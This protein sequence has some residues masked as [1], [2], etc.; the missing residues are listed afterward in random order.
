MTETFDVL[1]VRTDPIFSDADGNPADPTTVTLVWRY[2]GDPPTTWT[3]SSGQVVKVGTGNYRA[4]IP[5]TKKGRLYYKWIGVGGV[6]ASA[7]NFADVTT[8]F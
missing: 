7:E 6:D 2:R 4:D 8:Y 5:I 3:V 1:R